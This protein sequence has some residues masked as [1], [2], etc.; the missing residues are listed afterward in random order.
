MLRCLSAVGVEN[1]SSVGTGHDELG[2]CVHLQDHD[3][4][5]SRKAWWDGS[6]NPSVA[7]E[8]YKQAKKGEEREL[9]CLEFCV[10]DEPTES[11]RGRVQDITSMG[12]TVLG[13]CLFGGPAPHGGLQPP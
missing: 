7:M 3:L 5:G 9:E 11:L 6:H 4:V 2:T 8:G 12:D 10:D 1:A 13:S